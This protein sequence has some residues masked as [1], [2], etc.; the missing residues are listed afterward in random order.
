[1]NAFKEAHDN[2]RQVEHPTGTSIRLWW[3]VLINY[4]HY[5][6]EGFPY[7]EQCSELV[8]G[9]SLGHLTPRD[10]WIYVSLC[11]FYHFYAL[12]DLLQWALYPS[13]RDSVTNFDP[14]ERTITLSDW[15]IPEWYRIQPVPP[16]FGALPAA[17]VSSIPSVS[18][19]NSPLATASVRANANPDLDSESKSDSNSDSDSDSSEVVASTPVPTSSLAAKGKARAPP[20]R[21][22]RNSTKGM[23]FRFYTS[24]SNS[25]FVF[26]AA[27]PVSE[28][29]K[30][31]LSALLEST[32]PIPSVFSTFQDHR[33]ILDMAPTTPHITFRDLR[34]FL[35]HFSLGAVSV[36]LSICRWISVD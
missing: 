27:Q 6:A 9:L 7:A 2:H 15:D 10:S 17:A 22:T 3:E 12:S 26:L 14:C 35:S 4:C 8:H 1:M 28:A 34:L 18:V 13:N 24:L 31:E 25:D 5:G 19:A 29:Y 23:F 20:A 33:R 16:L 30:R 32:E 11:H 36:Y 21:T